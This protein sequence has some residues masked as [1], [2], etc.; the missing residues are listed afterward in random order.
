MSKNE[1][2]KTLDAVVEKYGITVKICSNRSNHIDRGMN[3]PSDMMFEHDSM[4]LVKRIAHMNMGVTQETIREWSPEDCKNFYIDNKLS[5]AYTFRE[6]F[7]DGD[8]NIGWY[9]QGRSNYYMTF[10]EYRWD[11]G[12]I[13]TSYSERVNIS[14]ES[15]I[16][17]E[18]TSTNEM[19]D[20]VRDLE[21]QRSVLNSEL[22]KLVT[23][24][25]MSDR[26]KN[27]LSNVEIGL[28]DLD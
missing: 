19:I 7:I 1:E 3:I 8:K 15:M 26:L 27:I 2:I 14:L 12:M 10:L 24:D 17:S 13:F 16:R 5:T 21:E 11:N 6:N 9:F 23:S 22:K 4:F 18:T 28:S 20:K 25:S